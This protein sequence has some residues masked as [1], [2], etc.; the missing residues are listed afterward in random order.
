M[1]KDVDDL[2]RRLI[3]SNHV[4][5]T[6]LYDLEGHIYRDSNLRRAVAACLSIDIRKVPSIYN[7]PA[8][9]IEKK[10][11][12]WE[13]WLTLCV[14]SAV[15]NVDCGCGYGRL[16]A[17]NDTLTDGTNIKAYEDFKI[18]L[19]KKYPVPRALFEQQFASVQRAV[20]RR[21]SQGTL[22]C[23]FKGK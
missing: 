18:E 9:W 13:A 8:E 21:R 22:S 4:F 12:T 23:L 6:A 17:V 10:A 5:Y 19:Q 15:F 1:D 16:S 3:R 2:R 7:S 11:V 20:I 14:Y